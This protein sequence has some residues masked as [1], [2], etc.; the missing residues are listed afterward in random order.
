M[1]QQYSHHVQSH[2]I[3]LPHHHV[4]LPDKNV[5]KQLLDF[6]KTKCGRKCIVIII[7]LAVIAGV[8]SFGFK[9]I[10][11]PGALGH[12]VSGAD[13]FSPY[14]S[15]VFPVSGLYCDSYR[16]TKY[17]GSPATTLLW[18]TS[19]Y[20]LNNLPTLSSSYNFSIPASED[21]GTIVLEPGEFYQWS[22]ILHA[23]SR[24]EINS[25]VVREN[26]AAELWV[27]KGKALFRE[28]VA[29]KQCSTCTKY[30]L[31]LCNFTMEQTLMH[32]NNIS[33]DDEYFFVYL[34]PT[35]QFSHVQADMSFIKLEYSFDDDDIYCQC[36]EIDEY[37][38][39][40]A[41][42]SSCSLPLTFNGY[43]LLRTMPANE[44][45]DINWEDKIYI[46]W[47]CDSAYNYAY[48]LLFCLPFV[49]IV[50][51]VLICIDIMVPCL[52]RCRRRA[53]NSD[54]AGTEQPWPA[55]IQCNRKVLVATLWFLLVLMM[56]LMSVC[57]MLTGLMLILTVITFISKVPDIQGISNSKLK[58][59]LLALSTVFFVVSLLCNKFRTWIQ[60][61]TRSIADAIRQQHRSQIAQNR[62]ARNNSNINSSALRANV[63]AHLKNQV[64]RIIF[65]CGVVPLIIICAVSISAMFTFLEAFFP[66]LATYSSETDSAIFIHGDTQTFSFNSFFCSEYSISSYGDPHLS[67]T[68][69][70]VNSDAIVEN[71]S[72]TYI[73]SND[74]INTDFFATWNFYLN[75]KSDASMKACLLE[76][77]TVESVVTLDLYQYDSDSNTH[78]IKNYTISDSCYGDFW[79]VSIGNI[80]RKAGKYM[81]ELSTE[82]KYP[83]KTHVEIELNR[84]LYI[85]PHNISSAQTCSVSF[86]TSD[87][88]T[89][90][91]PSSTGSMTG[92]ISVHSDQSAIN[93]HETLSVKKACHYD[94]ANWTALWLPV[95]LINVIIFSIVSVVI[96]TMIYKEIRKKFKQKEAPQTDS[97]SERLIHHEVN[98][99][100][101]YGSNTVTVATD[102][103]D[104]GPTGGH[105]A[106]S[107]QAS[108]QSNPESEVVR[109]EIEHTPDQD[110]APRPSDPMGVVVQTE[111]PLS[112]GNTTTDTGP[113]PFGSCSNNIWHG[114]SPSAASIKSISASKDDA[115]AVEHDT[116]TANI[117]PI[118]DAEFD[119]V[120]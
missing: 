107:D 45:V 68:L 65:V 41:C 69:H 11:G 55:L 76:D 95:L 88:C 84:Y 29:K 86:H 21:Q 62:R 53:G 30:D 71:H 13:Y 47:S 52:S 15:L 7:P 112:A 97:E 19:W 96:Q 101:N 43:I 38:E 108:T 79:Q 40:Y 73:N 64:M 48:F 77:D 9:F 89:A 116:D 61:K 78:I 58:L 31:P 60:T 93:W 109:V 115:R 25:C 20:I 4:N 94:M 90:A 36:E 18:N 37:F 114:P 8:L 54:T 118:M 56:S 46:T 22:F 42:L 17:S 98:A 106:N 66:V 63:V 113:T 102:T 72:V 12:E 67:A 91:A 28:W 2:L 100:N 83:I 92:I 51:V 74:S 14:T 57:V 3:Q 44:Y 50:V 120:I 1:Y 103:L 34:N 70:I 87:T 16:V 35:N 6:G 26:D 32:N 99:S 59:C 110:T 105:S 27:I 81:V 104:P 33:N 24:Y 117:K 39:Y 82:S 80:S 10:S 49:V 119:D 75:D 111:H 5:R 23:G 85:V